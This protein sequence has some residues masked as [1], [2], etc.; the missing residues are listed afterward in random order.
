[1]SEQ[2]CRFCHRYVQLAYYCEDCGSNCCSDCLHEDH[3]DHYICQECNSKKVESSNSEKKRICKDCGSENVAR[4]SQLIKS[5]PKCH[6]HHIVN[7]YE[8]KE[9]LEKKFLELIKNT[10]LFVDP[11]R[12]ILNK[13][14]V[15]QQKLYNVRN[16][17]LRY[18]H[19]PK[20]ESDLLALFKLFLYV[21]STLY[22]KINVHFHQLNQN[23]EYFFDAY[24]QPN[25][26]I[27]IIEGLFE[28]LLRSYDSI[29]D[30][31]RNNIETFDRSIESI[32]ENLQFIEK[33]NL[34]F[35]SYKK[36]LNLAEKEKPVFAIYAKLANGLDTQQRYKKDKGILFITNFD[37]SFVHEHGWI[38]KKKELI[39]KAPVGDLTRIREKGK[40]FKKL[41]IEFAYGKYEFSL[42][43][44]SVSK[45][46]EYIL[47]ARTFDETT[48]YDKSTALKLQRID[49]DLS[50]I[51]NFIEESINNFFSI[52]CQYNKSN[53]STLNYNNPNLAHNKIHPHQIHNGYPNQYF[54]P[55]LINSNLSGSMNLYN[56][57]SFPNLNQSP[58]I[59]PPETN[60]RYYSPGTNEQN[61]FMQNI[62][63]PN[64]LQNYVS[65]QFPRYNPEFSSFNNRNF[66]MRK[67]KLNQNQ[68]IEYINHIN[69]MKEKEFNTDQAFNEPRF[70]DYTKNHLTGLF[71]DDYNRSR[72]SYSYKRPSFKFDKEKQEK[73][74]ELNKERY[75]LKQTIKKLESKFDE[76]IISEVDFFKTYKNLQKDFYMIDKKVQSLKENLED[77]E[78][79]KQRSR[80]FD[81]LGF[82]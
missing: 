7:I 29:S 15:L 60:N 3:V 62:S 11:L 13:L 56:G 35:T 73:M 21:Q 17:P 4:V 38:K 68:D 74:L 41:Y 59:N 16:P 71:D 20:M 65:R 64:R 53:E 24:A 31:I 42:P 44:K 75:S 36:I 81:N 1:M 30:F 82:F 66:F 48:V 78:N 2:I 43:A 19:Y 14:L 8:K 58:V 51:E 55:N 10:R 50:D 77:L 33:L 37:L 57:N 70:Q 49:I 61:L 39:F 18:Y 23:K 45:V 80:D 25:S 26:N 79:I 63:N 12:E 34:Y 22:E 67:M 54:N 76:G 52:K 5:C 47:L 72:N 6:S 28:N 9:D 69:S 46:I 32:L 27:T 40:V